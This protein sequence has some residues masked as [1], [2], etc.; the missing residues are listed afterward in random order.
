[1]VEFALVNRFGPVPGA[2]LLIS[3]GHRVLYDVLPDGGRG[4]QAGAVIVLRI[5]GPGQSDD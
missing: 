4:R 3:Q 1:L 2:R 5:F